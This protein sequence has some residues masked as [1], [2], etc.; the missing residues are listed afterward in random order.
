[1]LPKISIADL[2]VLKSLISIDADSP[3]MAASGIPSTIILLKEMYLQRDS[4]SSLAERL[5]TVQSE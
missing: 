3:L 5:D 2:R 4:I 1:V